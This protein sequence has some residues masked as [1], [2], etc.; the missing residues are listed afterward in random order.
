MTNFR[1]AAATAATALMAF[2]TGANAC[3]PN[4]VQTPPQFTYNA[5]VD[6]RNAFTGTQTLTGT[7]TNTGTVTGT[8]DARNANTFAPTNTVAPA[9]TVAPTVEGSKAQAVGDVKV[10]VAG[11]TYTAPKPA[12]SSAIAYAPPAGACA[13]TG[14]FGLSLRDFSIS[15]SGSAKQEFCT[16]VVYTI[17]PTFERNGMPEA[18]INYVLQGDEGARKAFARAAQMEENEAARVA[19]GQPALGKYGRY[20]ATGVAPLKVEPAATTAAPALAPAPTYNP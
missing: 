17:V 10:T 3:T 11:D 9:I 5:G 4:C 8:V 14:A 7:L 16:G 19:A 12:V 6:V 18:A 1:R 15:L 13:N 20:L 2:N